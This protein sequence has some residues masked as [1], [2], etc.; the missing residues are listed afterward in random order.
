[1][2]VCVC[3]AISQC[4]CAMATRFI[5]G[6]NWQIYVGGRGE[7][8]DAD[9]CRA[10]DIRFIATAAGSTTVYAFPPGLV[11]IVVITESFLFGFMYY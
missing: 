2:C 10:Y 11:I 1:M 8:E 5:F 9:W 6:N 7:A 4:V 3:A